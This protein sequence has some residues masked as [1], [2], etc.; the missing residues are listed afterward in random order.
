LY[1]ATPSGLEKVVG[2][3]DW[4][5][6]E[7]AEF[8]ARLEPYE[9]RGDE[10][11]RDPGAVEAFR[12]RIAPNL[13]LLHDEDGKILGRACITV[14]LGR[15]WDY[16][17]IWGA[18]TV[19]GFKACGLS[20]IV[21][22]LPGRSL[23][24]SR[25][26][27]IPLVDDSSLARWADEQAALLPRI[28]DD[29]EKLSRCAQYVRL[30]L[31][32]TKGL[33]VAKHRG[34]WMSAEQ[35]AAMPDPPDAAVLVDSFTTDYQ[36]KHVESY[37]L[38]DSVFVTGSGGIPVLI[39][40][41]NHDEP[42]WPRPLH[43][44]RPWTGSFMSATLSGA[45]IEAL[46]KAWGVSLEAVISRNDFEREAEVPIARAGDRVISSSALRIVKPT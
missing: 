14:G 30:C 38:E 10:A 20:G 27:A 37:V 31:G 45:I 23:R 11:S 1:V 36:L 7:D 40:S 43:G 34:A 26:S 8:L 35:I 19:G 18:V 21:G 16:A 28:W 44:V 6:V 39:Q 32:S 5:T 3:E 13:R 17:G 9:H 41:R 12:K 2:A 24:A 25:D 15:E 42:S 4:M 29:P 46:C 33:P 22:I